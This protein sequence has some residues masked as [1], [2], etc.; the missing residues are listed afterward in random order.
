MGR[1]REDG[2]RTGIGRNERSGPSDLRL[3]G[4]KA[5][6]SGSGGRNSERAM[7]GQEPQPARRA[8]C[9]GRWRRGLREDDEDF[10]VFV[11]HVCKLVPWYGP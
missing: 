11:G 3:R 9:G 6:A 1:G 4:F 2:E 5:S 8:A 7:T 10:Y